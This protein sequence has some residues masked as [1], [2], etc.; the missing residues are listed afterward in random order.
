MPGG[1][2]RQRKKAPSNKAMSLSLEN[3]VI[4][5]DLERSREGVEESV[6]SIGKRILRLRAFSK[7][8]R[9]TGYLNNIALTRGAL[10]HKRIDSC[11]KLGVCLVGKIVGVDADHIPGDIGAAQ[12]L[13]IFPEALQG[14]ELGADMNRVAV[15]VMDAV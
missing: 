3:R 12:A 10:F 1:D 4:L 14:V 6:I 13:N 8:L 9:M 5:S 15:F 11:Q 2:T 7:T